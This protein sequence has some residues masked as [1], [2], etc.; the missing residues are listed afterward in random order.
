MYHRIPV[1]TD[2]KLDDFY[3]GSLGDSVELRL[4]PEPD[5]KN[6]KLREFDEERYH[7]FAFAHTDVN[8][9]IA[10]LPRE[11]IP[12]NLVGN[13]S[14]KGWGFVLSH[15]E[16]HILNPNEYR[17]PVIDLLGGRV[18]REDIRSLKIRL[19]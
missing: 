12:Y 19:Y 5:Y 6:I 14:I 4:N 15:E 9:E 16:E 17:E 3:K 11:K 1:Y 10:I 13:A 7:P 8:T 18:E 2:K